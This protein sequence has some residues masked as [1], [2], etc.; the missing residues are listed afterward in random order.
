MTLMH[1]CAEQS[2]VELIS[3]EKS[4]RSPG[5]GRLRLRTGG[6]VG[7]KRGR[8]AGNR[9]LDGLKGGRDARKWG[10]VG[11]EGGRVVWMDHR[12]WAGKPGNGVW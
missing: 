2:D 3:Q 7:P 8:E 11:L 6:L 5:A 4:G 10:L 12:K 9:G 1:S